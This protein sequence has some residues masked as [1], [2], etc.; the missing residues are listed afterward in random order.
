MVE[1]ISRPRTLKVVTPAC[2][3]IG[4]QE[5]AYDVQHT[6]AEV[7]PEAR[8]KSLATA[9]AVALSPSSESLT[10]QQYLEALPNSVNPIKKG[11]SISCLN[12]N[13]LPGING[14]HDPELGPAMHQM[15][16]IGVL[17]MP[18][19]TFVLIK[20]TRARLQRDGDEATRARL[21][22][23]DDLTFRE[24]DIILMEARERTLVSL[25]ALV[26]E[27]QP[28]YARENFPHLSDEQYQEYLR[29]IADE[30]LQTKIEK[31]K[32][33]ERK[34]LIE[35]FEALPEEI[36]ANLI[37]PE[38]DDPLYEDEHQDIIQ[39]AFEGLERKLKK[40]LGQEYEEFFNERRERY[41][42]HINIKLA[43][44]DTVTQKEFETQVQNLSANLPSAQLNIVET[45][46]ESRRDDFEDV[47][48]R[49]R[50]LSTSHPAGLVL[51]EMRQIREPAEFSNYVA[52][53]DR[54]YIEE[55]SEKPDK[56]VM[57]A[58]LK[59][60]GS[61]I[62]LQSPQ[63]L[64]GAALMP[65]IE[66]HELIFPPQER[67]ITK[68]ALDDIA[69][70]THQ[71]NRIIARHTSRPSFSAQSNLSLG[72]NL[73][74][75]LI[76]EISSLSPSQQ[77]ALVLSPAEIIALIRPLYETYTEQHTEKTG[78]HTVRQ[79]RADADK[80]LNKA[81]AMDG[82][83]RTY[84]GDSNLS[85]EEKVELFELIINDLDLP[86]DRRRQFECLKEGSPEL[87]GA[88]RQTLENGLLEEARKKQIYWA[89]QMNIKDT[90]ARQIEKANAS[91]RNWK[92]DGEVTTSNVPGI[93]FRNSSRQELLYTPENEEQIAGFIL[94][95]ELQAAGLKEGDT[96][97]SGITRFSDNPL[98]QGL[99]AQDQEE[100]REVYIRSLRYW[101]TGIERYDADGNLTSV[102]GGHAQVVYALAQILHYSPQSISARD[103]TRIIRN[104][105]RD[106]PSFRRQGPEQII[107]RLL[108]E[109]IMQVRQHYE[110]LTGVD[111][112]E[113]KPENAAFGERG[114]ER[115]PAQPHYKQTRVRPEQLL[116]A[117]DAQIESEQ[118][119]SLELTQ[120]SQIEGDAQA[121]NEQTRQI[122]HIL[123]ID[124]ISGSI[125]EHNETGKGKPATISGSQGAL[126]PHFANTTGGSAQSYEAGLTKI[127]KKAEESLR[128]KRLKQAIEEINQN[129]PIAPGP[130][131]SKAVSET[132]G[133][134]QAVEEAIQR[135][136]KVFSSL[137]PSNITSEQAYEI[138]QS[139]IPKIKCPENI[140]GEMSLFNDEVID[141][142]AIL[143]GC[144]DSFEMHL[145]RARELFEEE[146]GK[147]PEDYVNAL[148]H[149]L[150]GFSW[151]VDQE[152]KQKIG[153]FDTTN[154]T[155][156]ANSEDYNTPVRPE[157]IRMLLKNPVFF[158]FIM[159]YQG[160]LTES[161][162]TIYRVR[163]GLPLHDVI[164]RELIDLSFS[165]RAIE[166]LYSRNLTSGNR[167]Q[168]AVN[169]FEA[170]REFHKNPSSS[171]NNLLRLVA[172]EYY[173]TINQQYIK[174]IGGQRSLTRLECLRI[175]EI[176][177]STGVNISPEE[178]TNFINNEFHLIKAA[179]DE[180]EGTLPMQ[181]RR[182]IANNLLQI[183][184]NYL[185]YLAIIQA[186][187]ET[188]ENILRVS[189]GLP[190]KI[191]S[192]ADAP[193]LLDFGQYQLLQSYASVDELSRNIKES[194]TEFI[195]TRKIDALNRLAE[196]GKI[197]LQNETNLEREFLEKKEAFLE[198]FLEKQGKDLFGNNNEIIKGI[199]ELH[200]VNPDQKVQ[201]EHDIV[202]IFYFCNRMSSAEKIPPEL[203]ET[204][205]RLMEVLEDPVLV[206]CV[207]EFFDA[208]RAQEVEV[209]RD[210]IESRAAGDSTYI[211]RTPQR[212]IAPR[213]SE[214]SLP[215][216][217]TSAKLNAKSPVLLLQEVVQS[218]RNTYPGYSAQQIMREI[219]NRR[220]NVISN[221]D[222]AIILNYF[223]RLHPNKAL[224]SIQNILNTLLPP[225]NSE[226]G[227]GGTG[228][229]RTPPRLPPSG[230]QSGGSADTLNM[231]QDK[232]S[233][234]P[235]GTSFGTEPD[236]PQQRRFI[237]G[238]N[239]SLGNSGLQITFAQGNDEHSQELLG[240]ILG[241]EVPQDTPRRDPLDL[242][243]DTLPPEISLQ[244]SQA[245]F[246]LP[247]STDRIDGSGQP[248]GNRFENPT[249]G[250][251]SQQ[252]RLPD[253][254]PPTTAST[255]HL[256]LYSPSDRGMPG[257]TLDYGSFS[258]TGDNRNSI[259][260]PPIYSDPLQ[261]EFNPGG[262][263]VDDRPY[264]SQR[265]LPG[266]Q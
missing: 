194:I 46:I 179:I 164:P 183:P 262:F 143:Q 87:G 223:T 59:Q 163:R 83:I 171:L 135:T 7:N 146:Y 250:L 45:T 145:K 8:V 77:G 155:H 243:S 162:E 124:P 36:K 147:L 193:R 131:R 106:E 13:E 22:R 64:Y 26:L 233:G 104:V 94:G 205:L 239:R 34:K 56:L 151:L 96:M 258:I 5:A 3:K 122:Q 6:T 108:P 235:R 158:R 195:K 139:Y 149:H 12:Y 51:Y 222:R 105:V 132:L 133:Y 174:D 125:P 72:D 123:Y 14:N 227:E 215:A 172:S 240:R 167:P 148:H 58:A 207:I 28:E 236:Y 50:R 76:K 75:T 43:N 39:I 116:A 221:D 70:T 68:G 212:E 237:P 217:S 29:G 189:S 65:L 24:K 177:A 85:S 261:S 252:L 52:E 15:S 42:E 140:L 157:Q 78:E 255:E 4:A 249:G 54:T 160:A 119:A 71:S 53:C 196:A 103:L 241:P 202:Q 107:A 110:D 161:R 1:P 165:D 86:P 90:R 208:R 169:R 182:P 185:L 197:K 229:S 134:F 187:R 89:R 232:E 129:A 213:R 97:V 259:S 178:V 206:T 79:L 181:S 62:L 159:A 16:D 218:M 263:T 188:T 17:L 137:D 81:A 92:D 214:Q 67:E 48:A 254:G 153:F 102:D 120:T 127:A 242:N 201:Y 256:N 130:N 60:P 27:K 219:R 175:V 210:F 2:A 199:L 154:D 265:Q 257:R 168:D 226:E 211:V 245:P 38:L 224:Q 25:M 18:P 114:E 100:L 173:Q 23:D 190:L 156:L 152:R 247:G 109:Q 251:Q 209:F 95:R 228:V 88:E 118:T 101:G 35:Q 31:I 41:K 253:E 69:H 117:G 234:G 138:M 216:S 93:V 99:S 63:E 10:A 55:L 166:N 47:S 74:D 176:L 150:I 248:R 200:G 112:V 30:Q 220:S 184:Q 141:R 32:N 82:Y 203:K 230:P 11:G 80:L 37:K 246:R 84:R 260:P 180:N 192:E 66:D 91:N 142:Y 186:R 264:N 126:Y 231:P 40:A 204:G 111:L 113:Y 136:M 20:A 49:K 57:A 73:A 61:K 198:Q 244:Q 21:Q 9:F 128:I 144:Q 115:Q 266:S 121:E 98:L 19:L 44:G 33:L 238:E 170:L 191:S 225:N